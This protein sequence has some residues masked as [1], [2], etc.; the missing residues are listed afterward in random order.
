MIKYCLKNKLKKFDDNSDLDIEIWYDNKHYLE[1]DDY[2]IINSINELL[3]LS[4]YEN[5]ISLKI[6]NIEYLDIKDLFIF[7]NLQK[8]ELD[9][10]KDIF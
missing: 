7:T 1:D 9:N 8:L 3:F 10:I 4:N 6:S 2:I 5:I